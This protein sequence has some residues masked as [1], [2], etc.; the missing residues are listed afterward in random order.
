MKFIKTVAKEDAPEMNR[1][2][3]RI[4]ARQIKQNI[5]KEGRK[6]KS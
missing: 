1:R 4:L 3:R 2:A 5:K 6:A